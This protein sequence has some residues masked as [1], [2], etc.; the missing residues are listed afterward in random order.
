[1]ENSDEEGFNGLSGSLK[2]Y[3]KSL[4][5]E[6]EAKNPS[7]DDSPEEIAKKARSL[8][9]TSLPL[10]IDRAGLLALG[11]DSES[12]SLSAIKF[13]YN[14]VVPPQTKAPGEVDPMERLLRELAT[15]DG[16]EQPTAGDKD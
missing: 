1:M 2:S 12:V 7:V 3:Q 13:L 15:N 11:A 14:I 4:Q 10:L 9:I 8:V 5:E 16:K 6:W